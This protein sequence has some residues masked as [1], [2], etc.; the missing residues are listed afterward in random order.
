VLVGIVLLALSCFFV[1]IISF[2]LLLARQNEVPEWVWY[3]LAAG[4]CIF[5]AWRLQQGAE[6][7][8]WYGQSWIDERERYGRTFTRSLTR[9][10]LKHQQKIDAEL[11]SRSTP[12]LENGSQSAEPRDAQLTGPVTSPTSNG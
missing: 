8:L 3:V 7:R 9:A 6:L 5:L 11:R 1:P 4:I 10:L 2:L 12:A